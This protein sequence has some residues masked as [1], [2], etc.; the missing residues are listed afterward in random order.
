MRCRVGAECEARAREFHGCLT[1]PPY[2]VVVSLWDR[3]DVEL[4]DAALR[5]ARLLLRRAQLGALANALEDGVD[6]KG[7][8]AA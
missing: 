5:G 6:A 4:P 8:A 7:E 3:L 2:R 1:C